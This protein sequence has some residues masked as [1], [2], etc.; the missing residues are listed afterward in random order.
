MSLQ[1]DASQA[2]TH[3]R[4]CE[5]PEVQS[6]GCLPYALHHPERSHIPRFELPVPAK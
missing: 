5:C 2:E 1:G 3:G 4:H 6:I